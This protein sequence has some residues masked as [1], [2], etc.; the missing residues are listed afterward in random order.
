VL[1]NSVASLAEVNVAVIRWMLSQLGIAAE[2]HW[3]SRLKLPPFHNPN[4][5]LIFLCRLLDCET[6]LSGQG[7]ATTSTVPNGTTPGSS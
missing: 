5:R 4:D 1:Q 2:I 6:Y 3:E 7:G